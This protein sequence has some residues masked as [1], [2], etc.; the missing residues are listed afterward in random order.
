MIR[1]LCLPPL[2]QLIYIAETSCPNKDP[3]IDH[4]ASAESGSITPF[5]RVLDSWAYHSSLSNELP[6]HS[7]CIRRYQV[8]IPT[9]RH[10][11][12][13]LVSHSRDHCRHHIHHRR[14]YR[15]ITPTGYPHFSMPNLAANTHLIRVLDPHHSYSRS[16]RLAYCPTMT[17]S[18]LT[19][20]RL[21]C[22]ER[23]GDFLALQHGRLGYYWPC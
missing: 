11:H 23:D 19:R 9:N 18:P 5:D 7:Q 4:T 22:P 12:I 20:W 6:C 14:Q 17:L 21:L 2:A 1:S 8:P 10:L 16:L 13:R 15:G 3:P